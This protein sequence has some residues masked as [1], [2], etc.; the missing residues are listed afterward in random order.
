VIRA[1]TGLLPLLALAAVAGSACTSAVGGASPGPVDRMVLVVA[2]DMSLE[3]VLAVP[4]FAGLARAGGVAL[5]TTHDPLPPLGP[6]L[7]AAGIGICA[8]PGSARSGRLF[9]GPLY[10]CPEGAR[11]GRR[12]IVVD[13]IGR[14]A[15][16]GAVGAA[17]I[18]A[19]A[20]S[21]RPVAVLVISP[22][23]SAAMARVGDQVPPLI[24]AVGTPEQL[25][26][27]GGG[28]GTLTSDTTRR[29]GM[30]ANVDVGP[31]VLDLFGA[32]VPASMTGSPIRIVDGPA[33]LALHARYLEYRRVRGPVNAALITFVSAMFLLSAGVIAWTWSGRRVIGWMAGVMR[34]LVLVAVALPLALLAAGLLPRVTPPVVW[35]FVLLVP[36]ALA[37]LALAVRGDAMTP[38]AALGALGLAFVAVDAVIL[39]GRA[40]EL[41]LLGGTMFD[42][43]RFYG[44]PNAFIALVLAGSLFVAARLPPLPGVVLLVA[45]GLCVGAPGLGADLGGAVTLFVA[46]GLWWPL[47]TRPR[48]GW[49]EAGLALA[50]V[51]VGTAAVLAMN[52]FLPGPPSHIGRF[53][54]GAGL[55]PGGVVHRFW[56]RL[57]I[58]LGQ[59]AD[60][61]WVVIA[62]V[63]LVVLLWI[64]AAN[65]GPVGRALTRAGGPWRE[66]LIALTAA[67]VAA[68]V[69]NDTGV[70]AA[71]PVFIYALALAT[72]PVLVWPD[73][74]APSVPGS[75]PP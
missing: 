29:D 11:P 64:A 7:D 55:G 46:A 62:L 6:A 53:V 42:G 67:G 21:S 34:F 10:A 41:P 66:A 48:F 30:V 23:P 17:V 51:A 43:V 60:V 32:T 27:T 37:A 57:R 18:G 26:G 63:G 19:G 71:A 56:D 4:T 36:S 61:P 12:V 38:F 45:V 3:Q 68:F 73:V 28:F 24:E 25:F 5:M 35:P 70:A 72:Y 8:A 44:L 47:R 33:P 22:E 49:V 59:V 1:R 39:G 20:G 58:G 54:A 9:A 13:T 75:V 2:G 40:M 31:T 65:A 52:R 15:E 50:T 69:A 16:A 74:R 14:G